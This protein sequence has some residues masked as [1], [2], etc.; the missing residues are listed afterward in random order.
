V[1]IV[2]QGAGGDDLHVPWH[3]SALAVAN[4]GVAQDALDLT[5]GPAELGLT[6]LGFGLPF[7]DLYL[8]GTE[9]P[10]DDGAE[11]DL[12]AIGA[13]SFTGGSVDGTAEGAPTGIDAFAQV[14]WPQFLTQ[15]DEPT[16]PV[17]FVAVGA[18]VH[19]T[20]DTTE[21]DILVD[22]GADGVFAD[23]ALQA[24]V[25]VV[26]LAEGANGTVCVFTLPND[27]TA[28]DATYFQDYSNHNASIWGVV[29]DAGAL[30]L[31][32]AVHTLS[33]SI[34]ACS[35]VYSGDVPDDLSCD[36][37]GAMDAGT[38][39]YGPTL[40]VTDPALAISGLVAGGF[41]GGL[42]P[43]SVDVGSAAAG[44]DPSILV[45]FPNNAPNNQS[46]IVLTT[47]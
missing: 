5:G 25:M 41:W 6:E 9:D 22:L 20:T 16:E 40:D 4:S 11:G 1:D 33:Y 29:V 23:A 28:C 38:G 17:E 34:T 47:T 37:A 3:V 36:T 24:D 10:L 31:S 43:I 44:D 45:V 15:V 12:T 46:T 32:N 13:R 27:F 35:G 14:T 7:T 30:G 42:G 39:T 26:K 21:I 18:D 2:E 8:L 19:N